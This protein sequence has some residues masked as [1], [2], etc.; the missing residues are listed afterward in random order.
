MVKILFAAISMIALAAFAEASVSVHN[1]FYC[2]STD[3][4][5]P[6]NTMFSTIT[7]YESVRGRN[8]V[9]VSTCTPTK[10]WALRYKKMFF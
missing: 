7:T 6:Q 1:P 2:F 10:F 5:R 8:I 9:P 3:P 4:I